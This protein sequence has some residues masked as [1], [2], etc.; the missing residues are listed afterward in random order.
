MSRFDELVSS[1]ADLF[2]LTPESVLSKGRN[3]TQADARWVIAYVMRSQM[4]MSLPAIGRRLGRDHTTI[5]HGLRQIEK[6]PDLV[7]LAR[8]FMRPARKAA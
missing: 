8:T 1:V 4:N 6:R 3:S 7:S 2:G 5:L